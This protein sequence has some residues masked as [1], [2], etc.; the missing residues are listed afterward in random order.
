MLDL[1]YEPPSCNPASPGAYEW[2]MYLLPTN[3]EALY[4][5]FHFPCFPSFFGF[6]LQ[7]KLFFTS[8]QQNTEHFLKWSSIFHR[9]YCLFYSGYFS[10]SLSFCWS[11][12]YFNVEPVVIIRLGRGKQ[13]KMFPI[14]LAV[15]GSRKKKIF[16]LRRINGYSNI[17]QTCVPWHSAPKLT[18]S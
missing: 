17:F 12:C 5:F 2:L 7:N 15:R 16:W 9:K 1:K 13:D 6:I 18:N 3:K 8:S 11:W 14:G 4:L 10:L